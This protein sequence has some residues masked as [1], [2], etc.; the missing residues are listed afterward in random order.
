MEWSAGNVESFD[1][2]SGAVRKMLEIEIT[3]EGLRR[4]VEKVGE[5]RADLRDADVKAFQGGKLEPLYHEPPQV[6]VAMLDGGRAQTRASDA[7]PGVHEAAWIETKV[8]NLSTYTD[9]SFSLDPE[10]KPP[11]KFLDPPAV[12]KLAQEM[13]GFNGKASAEQRRKAANPKEPKA[14]E[15]SEEKKKRPERKVRTVVATTKSCEEFGPMVAA[16]AR[17]RG[18]FEAKKKAALGDGSLWIWGIVSTHLVGFV[19][20]LDFLHLLVHLYAAAQAAYK[21]QVDK[22]WSLYVKLVKLA[23]AG[24]VSELLGQLRKHAQRIGAPPEKCPEDDR[25]KILAGVIEYVD[26]NRDKMDYPRY[27]REGLPISSAPM[28]SLIKQVNLRVKGT[29]KFWIK[30]GLEAMLQVRAA[31]LSEDGR[32]EAHWA[33]RPL[34]RAASRSL[35]ARKAAA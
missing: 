2:G 18:F 29:D 35:F 20:I 9:V 8:A 6:A 30:E 31:Y 1:K 12:V 32:A 28:E 7:P 5:E 10:P 19:Q 27:R 25:R 24:R 11:A 33:K 16:D 14:P 23:W 3:P 4:L 34:G 22:A 21:A 13:K 17:R 15:R 26:K